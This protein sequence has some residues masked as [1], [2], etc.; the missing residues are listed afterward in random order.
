MKRRRATIG[1]LMMV[2]LIAAALLTAFQAGR[3]TRS[4]SLAGPTPFRTHGGLG[5]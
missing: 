1:G 2:V 5:P 3:R 4:T